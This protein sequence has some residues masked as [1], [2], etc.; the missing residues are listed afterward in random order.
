MPSKDLPPETWKAWW[1]VGV[2]FPAHLVLGILSLPLLAY[3]L[4]HLAPWTWALVCIY[5]PFYLYPAEKR[6]PGWKGFDALW[7]FFDYESTCQSY[8]GEFGVHG[9]AKVDPDGQY[10]VAAHPHG[11]VIFQRTYWRSERLARF[12]RRPWRML[13]ASVLFRIP[14][15]R[16]MTL[17]FGAVD[18]GRSNCERLLRA[19]ATVVVW[20]G[21]L[22]EANSVDEPR[23]VVR[24]RTRT[25]FIRLAVRS[26]VPVLPMFVFG[27][28][29]AVEAVRL[30][31]RPL[32]SWLKRTLRAS[33]NG[34][35]GRYGTPVPRRVPFNL[36]IGD[37]IAT[38]A[39][40]SAAA[41]DAEVARVHSLY[42]AELSRIYHE[43]RD[44]FGY[45]GRE[46][47]FA[48]EDLAAG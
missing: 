36:V 1:V 20:P 35:V 46:L 29:D 48:N 31:P 10:F 44:A 47:V 28:L 18:A 11:T 15:V 45:G 24:L 37:P 27:E 42:R 32:A 16:E 4:Y 9:G 43:H 6:Y 13:G 33:S 2:I 22:D 40:P 38:A 5:L 41:T 34:F 25:G 17:W 39:A 26:G 23:G 7:N 12:F 3:H 21:G 14:L 19:G 30:L 8:F